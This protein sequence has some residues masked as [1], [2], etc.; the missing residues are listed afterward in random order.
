M[1][2]LIFIL[3]LLLTLTTA[4]AQQSSSSLRAQVTVIRAGTLI[5]GKSDKP[6]HD[7]VIVVRGNRIESVGDAANAKP[8]ADAT[9]IDLSNETVLPG[10]IDSHTHI[11]LQGEDPA[12]GGYDANI[13]T[14]PLAMRAAR[15]TVSA[16]RALEQGF[17]TLRDVETEG[18]GYGDV[19][20]KQAIEGGYI[21]GPR[22]LVATRAISTTGGYPLE[23][24][25]PELEMPKGAQIV[26]GPVEARKAAREQLDHGADWIKVYMTHRSWVGKNG[27]LVSQPTLTVEELRAVVDETHGWGKKVACHAYSGIGL[28]RALDGGCDSIEHGLD[29]DDAAIAQMLK[30]GTWYVPTLSVYYTDWAAADTADGQRDR[31]RASVHEVSFKR[32]MKAG[33]KIVFGTDMGG[34]PWTEPIAQEFSRMVEFGMLPMDAI[35]SATS[36]AAVML[37]MEGR[38]GVVAPGALADIVAVTG[39]PLRDIK[40]LETV[41]FVM[42]DGKVFREK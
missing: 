14:A 11:F 5:D 20:I 7:Q 21:P 9:V 26:D 4:F 32:A 41:Q 15:A 19:G 36:R 12:K 33:V 10:L 28:H 17:T 3:I 29:L 34:I 30:Q 42:K 8:P 13:L 27:E 6:R 2:H 40:V 35:Q 24:Y 37:D 16:R 38:I 39:D 31:L 25:A 23:G 1:K 22:L 18:A